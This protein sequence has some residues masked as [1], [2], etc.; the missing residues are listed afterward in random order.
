[1]KDSKSCMILI[2]IHQQIK[3]DPAFTFDEFI[4][5]RPWLESASQKK[6]KI[7]Y[8]YHIMVYLRLRNEETCKNHKM[9][10]TPVEFR[11]KDLLEKKNN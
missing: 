11:A 3:F 1:M 9:L 7:E 10:K 2:H 4:E 8:Q 5:D 6:Q